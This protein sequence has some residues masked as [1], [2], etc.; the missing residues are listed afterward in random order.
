M[1]ERFFHN[2][3]IFDPSTKPQDMHKLTGV[4]YVY[5][6][7]RDRHRPA[8][9]LIATLLYQLAA[10][11]P[12]L[13]SELAD[14][15]HNYTGNPEVRSKTRPSLMEYTKA[16]KSQIISYGK[17]FIVLDGLDE[18]DQPQR[19]EICK[20]YEASGRWSICSQHPKSFQGLKEPCNPP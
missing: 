20:V 14:L 16:L 4:G 6:D 5:C 7:Y 9:R 1:A 19:G 2:G 18:Q 11:S 13:C 8:D 10:S 17:V 12:D 3:R 15:H